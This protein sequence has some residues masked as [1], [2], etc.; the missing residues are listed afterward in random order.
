M[1]ATDKTANAV[2]EAQC[3]VDFMERA[4]FDAT[5]SDFEWEAGQLRGASL[6]CQSIAE[7]LEVVNTHLNTQA[8]NE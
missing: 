1:N 2:F 3:M 7:R 8:G 5:S 6:V 4:F